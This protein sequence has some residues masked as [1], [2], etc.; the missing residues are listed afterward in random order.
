M[1]YLR[2]HR[3]GKEFCC[4]F[5]VVGKRRI[6]FK[7]EADVQKLQIASFKSEL[8]TTRPYYDFIQAANYCINNNIELEQAL[9]WM[10]RAISFRVMGEKTTER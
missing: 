3:P 8:R 6:A 1:A 9:A 2:I 5:H 10:D 4:H 7:V